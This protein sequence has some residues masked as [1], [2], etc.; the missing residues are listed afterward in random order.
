MGLRMWEASEGT[1]PYRAAWLKLYVH[2]SICDEETHETHWNSRTTPAWIDLS[3][4][5]LFSN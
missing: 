5:S 3:G 2:F 1:E 4:V